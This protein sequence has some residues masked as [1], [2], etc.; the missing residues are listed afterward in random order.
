L[1]QRE[2]HLRG[3][4]GL[5]PLRKL[6]VR[7]DLYDVQTRD[8]VVRAI[9]EASA[10]QTDALFVGNDSITQENR[11][12]IAELTAPNHLPSVFG[13]REFVDAGD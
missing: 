6:G 7:A 11:S 9:E 1:L 12:L 13:A 4:R 8:G 10:K 2:G 5:L 3:S